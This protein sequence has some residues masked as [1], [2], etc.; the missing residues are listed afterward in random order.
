MK[1]QNKGWYATMVFGLIF[2]VD[3]E[4]QIAFTFI[5]AAFVIASMEP[6]K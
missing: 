5:A 1:N 6:D 2:I 4:P 3:G